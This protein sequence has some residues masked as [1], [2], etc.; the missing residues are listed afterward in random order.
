[1]DLVNKLAVGKAKEL[2]KRLPELITLER[3]I[4]SFEG[5][6]RVRVEE[7]IRHEGHEFP[8]YSLVLG[9]QEPEAPAFGVFGGIHGLERIGSEVV[10]AWMH[11]LSEILRWDQTF[12]DRLEKSRLVFMPIVNPVGMFQM[13]RSNGNGVDLMRNS[14]V[15]AVEKPAFLLGGHHFS[16]RLP[17]Y[18]GR[19]ESPATMELEAQAVC[20]V[21]EREIFP[22][23]VGVSLDV[24][25]GFG[26]MDQLWFPYA[27]TVEPPLHCTEIMAL[28]RLFDR[29]YPNHFY[30]IEPQAKNYTT[31]G[32]LWDWLYD[33]RLNRDG[34]SL[35]SGIFIPFTLELGSWTW[36]K[37]NPRQLFSSLG[38]FNPIKPHRLQR[39]LR[40]HMT[41]L[42]FIHRAVISPQ[43]WVDLSDDVRRQLR[44][45][46]EDV[47]YSKKS[48]KEMG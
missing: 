21:V 23:R 46:A 36:L 17:W 15:E 12:R 34:G 45:R 1:M 32:D 20:R 27:K 42:D 25:S 8:I 9:S 37:K 24:H 18:R 40:R 38:P 14:P 19:S 2:K 6:A 29:S 47:W 35:E 16:H 11:T 31:H 22:S 10:L 43:A 5:L 48:G 7:T 28:K 3:L 13:S 26:M 41:L 39:I 4:K 30:K 44:H 33:S